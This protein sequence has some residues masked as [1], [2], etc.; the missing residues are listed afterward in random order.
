MEAWVTTYTSSHFSLVKKS[1]IL[2][3]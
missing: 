1:G 2:P 3:R